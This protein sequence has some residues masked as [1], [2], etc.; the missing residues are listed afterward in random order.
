MAQSGAQ[1][2]S[3]MM[4][5]L[6]VGLHQVELHQT[7]PDHFLPSIFSIRSVCLLDTAALYHMTPQVRSSTVGLVL[8]ECHCR[9]VTAGVSLQ[10]CHCGSVTAGVSLQGCHCGSVTAGVHCRGVT[11]GVSLR[12]CHCGNVTAG[13]SLREYH[14]GSITAGG[15]CSEWGK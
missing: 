6:A 7:S 2:L 13:V 3:V 14:C 5:F 10:G 15:F 4:W 1:G 12:E 11:A 9:G 8:R